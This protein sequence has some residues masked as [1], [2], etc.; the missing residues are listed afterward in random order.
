M[1]QTTNKKDDNDDAV[2]SLVTT[3]E[4]S[5]GANTANIANGLVQVMMNGARFPGF[6]SG[7][8][9]S[10]S[11]TH[12]IWKL[13]QRFDS[14]DQAKKWQT[15]SSRLELI[16]SI[17]KADNSTPVEVSDGIA[18][19]LSYA[20]VATAISTTVKPE[21]EDVFFAWEAKIQGAQAQFPGYRGVYSATSRERNKRRVVNAGALRYA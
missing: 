10:P 14:L 17:H 13:V 3:I 20:E 11:D 21:K 12:N 6:W 15:A 18:A 2:V 5:N 19:K 8:I 4:D 7:E 16:K 1:T 9:L